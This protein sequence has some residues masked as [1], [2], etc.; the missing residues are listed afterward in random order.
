MHKIRNTAHLAMIEEF[1][2][3]FPWLSKHVIREILIVCKWDKGV[4]I[5]WIKSGD[6]VYH[7]CDD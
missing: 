5:P 6:Y 7:F 2:E 3:R 4:A 1:K